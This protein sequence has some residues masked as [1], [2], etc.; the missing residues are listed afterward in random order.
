M[1]ILFVC[2]VLILIAS[3]S[4]AQEQR[5]DSIVERVKNLE[6]A[7]ERMKINLYRSHNE[8]RLGTILQVLG[9]VAMA[10]GASDMETDSSSKTLFI[11]GASCSAV[12]LILQ[13]DS[14]K[15]IGRA[16][17]RWKRN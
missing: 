14:H 17:R 8:F 5:Y 7:Q 6:L 16:A 11:A 9:A 2:S 13:I 12:G 15:F 1:K 4:Q 3:A 10:A